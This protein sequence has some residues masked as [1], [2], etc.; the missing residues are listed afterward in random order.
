MLPRS[1]VSLFDQEI[2]FRRA[3]D[4]IWHSVN[5][6]DVEQV[7]CHNTVNR[8]AI[9][10]LIV[11]AS[12]V[13]LAYLF[14]TSLWLQIPLFIFAFLAAVIGIAGLTSTQLVLSV[15]NDGNIVRT[16]HDSKGEVEIFAASCAVAISNVRKSKKSTNIQAGG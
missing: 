9:I 2:V 16:C 14:F 10:G 7:S 11:S 1:R 3:D 6:T 15:L 13:L 4:S 12:S 8:F 5:L